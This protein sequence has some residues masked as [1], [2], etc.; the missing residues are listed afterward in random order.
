MDVYITVNLNKEDIEQIFNH[1][2]YI[3]WI[4]DI[5]DEFGTTI[6]V[7]EVEEFISNFINSEKVTQTYENQVLFDISRIFLDECG[8]IKDSIDVETCCSDVECECGYDIL[9]NVHY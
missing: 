8:F 2:N 3:D 1:Q 9:K 4:L 5:A 7:A 6:G